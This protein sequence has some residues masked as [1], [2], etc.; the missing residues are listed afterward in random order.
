MPITSEPTAE[1]PPP[2]FTKVRHTGIGATSTWG[3]GYWLQTAGT[4]APG[5]LDDLAQGAHEA[6]A[7]TV[8]DLMGTD[9]SIEETTVTYYRTVDEL[10]GSYV[11]HDAGGQTGTTI[12]ASAAMVLSWTI[13]SHYRGGKPRTYLPGLKASAMSND[14]LW[15]SGASSDVHDAAVDWLTAVNALGPGGISSV[16]MGVLHFFS[17]GLA[18]V[19][20][21]FSGYSGVVAR[22]K[23]GSQRRRIAG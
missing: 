21:T 5:D 8:L 2:G 15:D 19:P 13:A 17:A 3:L 18:L 16:I 4:P 7:S 11:H 12:P 6:F 1:R 20:P 23:I 14:S 9:F 22:R 10:V